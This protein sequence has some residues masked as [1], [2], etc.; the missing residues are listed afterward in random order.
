MR[1]RSGVMK[2]IGWGFLFVVL[3]G[4]L[5]VAG[6]PKKPHII[7]LMSDQQ[8]WDAVGAVNPLVKTPALDGL[9][10]RGVLFDQA[11]C[12]APMCV[13]SR[14]SMMLGLYASQVGVLSNAG[15]LSDAELPGDPLPEVLRKAGYQTAGFGNVYGVEAY[16]GVAGK[17]R[18]GLLAHLNRY[19]R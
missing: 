4:P 11:V 15:R 18:E 3:V 12:Q 5:S 7:V 19:C 2:R 1:T 17:M 6:G 9:A 10:G 16:A 13:P 14:Y 8:R